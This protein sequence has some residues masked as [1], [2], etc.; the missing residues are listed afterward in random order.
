LND[1]SD[2][3]NCLSKITDIRLRDFIQK[4]IG[5]KEPFSSAK[6]AHDKI[7]ELFS[8]KNQ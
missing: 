5:I 6:E 7:S 8:N 4:L 2:V 1:S 3:Q